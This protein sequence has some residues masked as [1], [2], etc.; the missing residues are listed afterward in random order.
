MACHF[1]LPIEQSNKSKNIRKGL[2]K[3]VGLV[4]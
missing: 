2:W 4:D 3:N 1:S